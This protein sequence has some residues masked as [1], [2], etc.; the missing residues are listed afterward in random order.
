MYGL[1]MVTR[2]IVVIILQCIQVLNHCVVHLKLT[3]FMTIV[4]KKIT[5]TVRCEIKK[6]QIEMLKYHSD[7]SADVEQFILAGLSDV[8]SVPDYLALRR[9]HESIDASQQGRLP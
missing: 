2:L 5:E 8:D 6:N 3:C 7:L 9:F 1:E 4:Q